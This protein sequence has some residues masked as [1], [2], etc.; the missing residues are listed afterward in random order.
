M[1]E[2]LCHPKICP[3]KSVC[4]DGHDM[5]IRNRNASSKSKE[6]SRGLISRTVRLDRVR[7]G[8]RVVFVMLV[9]FGRYWYNRWIR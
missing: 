5:A 8:C 3:R 1:F 4:K 9:S 2:V 6:Q 7:S